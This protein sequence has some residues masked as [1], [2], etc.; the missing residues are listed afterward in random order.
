MHPIPGEY[1]SLI[2]EEDRNRIYNLGLFSS[3]DVTNIDSTYLII[4]VETHRFFPI[5]II[6]YNEGKGFSYGAGISYYESGNVK[7]SGFWKNDQFSKKCFGPNLR[8][9][10]I[11]L[12]A[13][14][15]KPKENPKTVDL[16]CVALCHWVLD[17]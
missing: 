6:D 14:K 1:D 9:P 3:V 17:W 10:H 7:Y 11:P 8:K 15:G 4:L 12:R 5:P 16:L 13:H 2:A